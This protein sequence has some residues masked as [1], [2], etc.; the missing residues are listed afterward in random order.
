MT[1]KKDRNEPE[2]YRKIEKDAQELSAKFANDMMRNP[3]WRW[4]LRP[5]RNV[6]KWVERKADEA[7]K[8][9]GWR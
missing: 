6:L 2:E 1:D 4:F 8:E 9:D 5:F 3:R 7:L